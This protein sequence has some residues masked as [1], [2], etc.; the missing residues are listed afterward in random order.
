[1]GFACRN[2]QA[3]HLHP[4]GHTAFQSFLIQDQPREDNAGRFGRGKVPEE[5]VRVGHLWHL[6]GMNK[7][8][9]LDDIDP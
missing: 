6:I 9:D 3:E 5:G 8:S 2:A 7:G 1:M 4:A